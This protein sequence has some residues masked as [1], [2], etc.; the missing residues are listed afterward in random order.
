MNLTQL[1][2]NE[3]CNICKEIELE[4]FVYLYYWLMS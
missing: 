2:Y 3:Y 1:L 4:I